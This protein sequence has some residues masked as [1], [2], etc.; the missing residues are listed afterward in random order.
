MVGQDGQCPYC[1]GVFVITV[2]AEKAHEA[3]APVGKRSRRLSKP[4]KGHLEFLAKHGVPL[5]SAWTKDEAKQAVD[6]LI[7]NLRQQQPATPKQV[8]FLKFLG[9]DTNGL[10]KA[11]ASALIDAQDSRGPLETRAQRGQEWQMYRIVHYPEL[12]ADERKSYIKG[13]LAQRMH[14]Y[15]RQ[16]IVAASERLTNQKIVHVFDILERD[17]PDWWQSEGCAQLFYSRLSIEYPGCCDG[18]KPALSVSPRMHSR[19][20]QQVREK[21]CLGIVLLSVGLLVSMVLFVCH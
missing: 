16:R 19:Q 20:A 18:R 7:Q 10:S 21:G 4:A 1:D 12:Y 8:A 2:E 13:E 15:V 3:P 6:T 14:D 5:D 11:D 17:D 9:Y